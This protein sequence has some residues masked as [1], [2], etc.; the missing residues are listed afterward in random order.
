MKQSPWP[1]TP[2][3]QAFSSSQKPHCNQFTQ[4]K[5]KIDSLLQQDIKLMNSKWIKSQESIK[6]SELEIPKHS[7]LLQEYIENN[8]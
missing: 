8:Y 3:R 6:E 5:Q 4:V 1:Q 7:Q 2:P